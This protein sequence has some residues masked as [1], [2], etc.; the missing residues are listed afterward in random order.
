MRAR[1]LLADDHALVCQGLKAMLE[2]TYEVIG[3]VHDGAAVLEQVHALAPDLVLLDLLMPNRLGLD[4]CRDIRREA[5]NTKVLVVSM[6]TERIYVDEAFRA[7]AAGFVVKLSS[8]TDL[9]RAVE[10]VLA[11]RTYRN[12]K[13]EARTRPAVEDER[14]SAASRL[15][16]PLEVLSRRQRQVFALLGLGKT[17][18]EIAELLGVETKTVE[19]HRVK[20]EKALGVTNVRALQQLCL[21]RMRQPGAPSLDDVLMRT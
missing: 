17:T 21:E 9:L 16:D 12:P 19:F 3:M 11:G 14:Q 7:G 4:V 5:P 10:T 8:D 1:V 13:F 18:Q 20:V 6:Q 15:T 2:P